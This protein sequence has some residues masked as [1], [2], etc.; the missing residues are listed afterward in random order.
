MY[1][2]GVST[3]KVAKITEELCGFEVSSSQVSKCSALLDEEIKAWRTKKLA[4]FP[5]V[6]L[7]AR[8]EK[9]RHG[10]QVVSCAVLIAIGVN[11]DGIR[12]VLGV[13]V[14]LSE[15]EV[16]WRTFLEQLQARGLHGIKMFTS[17]AH[18]GLK[19]ALNAVFPSVPWQ[20][21]Q[22]HLQQNAQSYVPKN[23]MKAAVAS[24]I[25]NIF[26]APSLSEAD[27]FLRLTVEKYAN[28]APQL[29]TWMEI[30]IPESL[31]VFNLPE[32]QR[33]KLRTSNPLERVN[34]EIKRRTK[35]VRIFPNPESCL[36]L[37]SALLM[38]IA[39][40]WQNGKRYLPLPAE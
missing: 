23:D 20:R 5:Y 40:E 35:V 36:R 17:D 1:V 32:A 3:R 31:T 21:C 2:E 13:S 39:D 25:R 33:K 14:A 38:E 10:N 37:V 30:N 24:D 12:D 19:A 18:S 26:N 28:I 6:M 16:H 11:E 27:R 29:S 7:D 15:Q 9:V 34:Q 22:F 4:C 8:Y